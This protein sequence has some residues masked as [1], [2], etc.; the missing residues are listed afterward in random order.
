MYHYQPSPYPNTRVDAA[1][2]LR[3][4]AIAGIILIHFLEH[5]GLYYYPVKPTFIDSILR[6]TIF[7]LMAGK[8]YG[9]FAMLHPFH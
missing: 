2:I 8:M 7:F 4:I 9:I 5:M 3:G 6:E 1:D